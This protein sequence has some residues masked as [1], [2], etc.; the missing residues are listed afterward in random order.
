MRRFTPRLTWLGLALVAIALLAGLTTP[1]ASAHERRTVANNKADVVVGWI[2]EPAYVEE[3]NGVDFRV[4]KAGTTEP[5]EG[6]EKSVKVEVTKGATKKTYDL[7][8]RF[9]MKGAYTA[10]LIPT[11]IGD[12]TFRFF[13]EIDGAP[14]NETFESG[15]GRFNAIQALALTQFPAPLPSTAQLEAQVTAANAAADSARTL[16]LAGIVVGVIGIGVGA[17]ALLLRRSGGGRSTPSAGS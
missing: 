5:I 2:V 17:A 9:G 14:I 4:M 11:S 8:T 13:G 12:Y 3:P 6:L 1:T 16:G 7:K 15:P 10:D